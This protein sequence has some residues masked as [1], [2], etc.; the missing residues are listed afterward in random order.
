M[1]MKRIAL[2]PTTILTVIITYKLHGLTT[3]TRHWLWSKTD[4]HDADKTWPCLP[5]CWLETLIIKTMMTQCNVG[6]AA[7]PRRF[8]LD[9]LHSRY[10]LP[11]LFLE[12]WIMNLWRID[13]YLIVNEG[14]WRKIFR[15]NCLHNLSKWFLSKG[16]GRS[17]WM[18]SS[19]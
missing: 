19:G 7:H 11:V 16:R 1:T 6:I 12:A 10:R 4:T 9:V 8:W 17:R 5:H 14:F 18:S 15:W 13:V 2:R 3:W